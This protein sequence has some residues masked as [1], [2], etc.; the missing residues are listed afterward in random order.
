MM[1]ELNEMYIRRRNKVMV[2]DKPINCTDVI[3]MR[4]IATGIQNLETYGY[5]L[6]KEIIAYYASLP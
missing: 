4:V 3:D 1:N 6:Y 2:C 5:N